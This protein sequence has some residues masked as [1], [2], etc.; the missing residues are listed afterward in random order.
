MDKSGVKTYGSTVSLPWKLYIWSTGEV[1]GTTRVEVKFVDMCRNAD[2]E[3]SPL[4]GY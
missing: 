4:D 3:D 2:D 1:D